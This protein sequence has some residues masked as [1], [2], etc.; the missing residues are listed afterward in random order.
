MI[1]EF[2]YELKPLLQKMGKTQQQLQLVVASKYFNVE[3]ILS[4]YQMGQRDFGENRVQDALQKM[5]QLPSDIRWHFIGH[6]QK[7]KINKIIGLF[8]LIH[9]IDSIELA[10]KISDKSQSIQKI[11]LQVNT[12]AE[13][14][15]EGFSIE[16]CKRAVPIISKLLHIQ[17][18]GLMTMA[19]SGASES[20]IRETFS[21][22]R[23]L[24]MH[25]G[26]NDW[27][28]SMGMSQDYLI[29]IEEGADIVRIGSRFLN[30][31]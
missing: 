6:L 7:N 11:L 10:Q 15:K 31:K 5:S 9:S 13:E 26:H 12:S 1:N 3:Q 27:L 22:L 17:I 28:L 18:C 23:E 8:D 2:F 30:L 19:P 16:E 24:K 4:L 20:K 14:S 29:A 25:L 21:Q